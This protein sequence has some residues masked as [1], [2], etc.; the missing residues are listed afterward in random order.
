MK[1][2]LSLLLVFALCIGAVCLLAACGPE[3]IPIEI[4]EPPEFPD[5][6]TELPNVPVVGGWEVSTDAAEAKMPKEAREAFDKAME[7]LDGASYVPIAYLGS[8][9]VAGTNYAYLCRTVILAADPIVK[10]TLVKVYSDLEGNASILDIADVNIADYTEDRGLEFDGTLT[11]GWTY[12]SDY[13]ARLDSE[14]QS[15]YKAATKGMVGAAYTPLALMGSQTV[16]GKNYAFLCCCERATEE[17]NATLAV[18]VIYAG[19]DGTTEISSFCPF[20]IG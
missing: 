7:E 1:K 13:P 18:L 3:I 16:A 14:E 9:V 2:S 8:Q 5:A 10:L 17:Y 19:T 11:G 20:P 12:C 4:S 6:A 15:A